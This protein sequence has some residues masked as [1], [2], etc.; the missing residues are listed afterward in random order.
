M[1]TNLLK[2]ISL[3]TKGLFPV[4]LF[5][6]Y[7]C[8]SLLVE[9]IQEYFDQLI[10]HYKNCDFIEFE[11]SAISVDGKINKIFKVNPK[12]LSKYGDHIPGI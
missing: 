7:K 4:N 9:P 6:K 12:Y 10:E 3:K 2:K 11:N 5:L 8:K 1:D